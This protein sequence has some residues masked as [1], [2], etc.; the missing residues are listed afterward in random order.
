MLN[1]WNVR[2]NL[3]LLSLDS[4]PAWMA[5]LVDAA[6]SK[7]AE[8]TLVP[9]RVRLWALKKRFL[10]PLFSLHFNNTQSVIIFISADIFRY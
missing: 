3:L 10:K 7:S 2:I 9:V 4:N 1:I 5:K 6:D 8:V